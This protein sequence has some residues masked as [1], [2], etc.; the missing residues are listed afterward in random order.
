VAFWAV[1]NLVWVAVDLT[2]VPLRPFWLQRR[3]QPIPALPWAVSLP[4]VPN[5]TPWMDPLKGIEPHRETQAFIS[6]FQALDRAMRDHRPGMPL[7]PQQRELTGRQVRLSQ[8]MVE[9]DPFQATVGSG[10]LET[11]KNILRQ[12]AQQVSSKEAVQLLLGQEWLSRHP[13]QVE[14]EFWNNQV[15]PLVAR[16]Y[17]RSIDETGR[18]TDHFWR[19]DLL[20]FQSVFLL[21]ILL[22][23]L[24]LRHKLPST[25]PLVTFLPLLLKPDD[26]ARVRWATFKAKLLEPLHKSCRTLRVGFLTRITLKNAKTNCVRS[27]WLRA[28]QRPTMAT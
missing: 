21:D 8:Q 1:V 27:A 18:P 23:A 19:W 15:L 26:M 9:S 12:R 25:S 16:N 20:L 2:Y 17:W 3:V 11:I 22:R 7:T 10:T 28:L 24:R 5:I 6:A 13:W 4:L 14:R